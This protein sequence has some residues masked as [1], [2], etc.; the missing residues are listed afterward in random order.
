MPSAMPQ[1]VVEQ[2]S[3]GTDLVCPWDSADPHSV[4]QAA[5][6][7]VRA[8]AIGGHVGADA[9]F[10]SQF[11]RLELVASFG[12]GYDN[13]DAAWAGRHGIVV[14]NTPD[15][16]NEDVADTALG[17]MIATARQLPAAERYLR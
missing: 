7:E 9:Q 15:V 10:L 16:L 13:I 11:P 5:A 2:L 17:L 8:L 1:A 3:A 6:A 12:V 4:I 14:T